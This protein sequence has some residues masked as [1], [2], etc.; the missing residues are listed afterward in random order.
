M[1]NIHIFF[2][3]PSPC[4]FLLTLQNCGCHQHERDQQQ[5]TCSFHYCLH[6]E[7]TRQRNRPLY[8]K[9]QKWLRQKTPFISLGLKWNINLL[10]MLFIFCPLYGQSSF[11][12]CYNSSRYLRFCFAKLTPITL[13]VVDGMRSKKKEPFW[14]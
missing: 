7:E 3:S 6:T 8:R 5:V 2:C 12:N 11:S 1:F 9:G 4:L 13:S 14:V 10:T